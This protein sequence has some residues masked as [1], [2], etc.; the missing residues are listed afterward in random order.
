MTLSF[1]R[2]SKKQAGLAKGLRGCQSESHEKEICCKSASREGGTLVLKKQLTIQSL[3]AS[4]SPLLYT[5]LLPFPFG[6]LFSRENSPNTPPGSAPG[7]LVANCSLLLPS[8]YTT[9]TLTYL[10]PQL[11]ACTVT[12]GRT[13]TAA[14]IHSLQVPCPSS[15]ASY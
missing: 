7:L 14:P 13:V 5:S 4:S 6:F 10:A 15:A 1:S 2:P 3:V 8:R 11:M 9:R 12:A